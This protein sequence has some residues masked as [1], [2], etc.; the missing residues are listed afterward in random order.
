MSKSSSAL[1]T[2]LLFSMVASAGPNSNAELYVNFG[3][4]TSTI[5]SVSFHN[6][7]DTFTAAIQIKKA[8]TLYGYGF[9]VGFDTAH[10]QFISCTRD[11]GS[12]KNILES[13]GGS[14]STFLCSFLRTD[15]TRISIGASL[16]GND[17]KVCPDGSGFLAF[18]KFRKKTADTT[19]IS[20]YK[21]QILDFNEIQDTMT[22]IPRGTILPGSSAIL[23]RCKTQNRFT[24]QKTGDIVTVYSPVVI[25]QYMQLFSID[26]K[27]VKRT[28]SCTHKTY[29]SLPAASGK[30]CYVLRISDTNGG[31]TSL[32][33]HN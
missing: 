16:L 15:S 1:L 30:S 12:Q 11:Y 33:I 27:C 22:S 29:F 18:I 2:I 31:Q 6:V 17:D 7:S 4:D 14:I 20:I 3:S 19:A 26:G 9:H 8:V 32:T 28:T 13:Q 25:P 10:L 24:I 5:D 21:I 23:K